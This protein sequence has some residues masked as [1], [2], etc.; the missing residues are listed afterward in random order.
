L[1]A[2]VIRCESKEETSGD[3]GFILVIDPITPED[4]RRKISAACSSLK[5]L[6]NS[7]ARNVANGEDV[8]EEDGIWLGE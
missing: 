5:R 1:N 3:K 2:L 6:C 7:F 4:D 8:D